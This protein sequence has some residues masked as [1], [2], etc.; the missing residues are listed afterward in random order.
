MSP[1]DGVTRPTSSLTDSKHSE[2]GRQWIQSSK[3]SKLGDIHAAIETLA[4]SLGGV[5]LCSLLA[6]V[7]SGPREIIAVDIHDSK[8]DIARSLGATAVYNARDPGGTPE[9]SRGN[10]GRRGLRVRNGRRRLF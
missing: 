9:D 10:E 7:A 2:L 1:R 6:A 4:H 3:R 5:G 8:L